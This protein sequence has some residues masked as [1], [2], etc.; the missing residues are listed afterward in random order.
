[1]DNDFLWTLLVTSPW[2]NF[3]G[4]FLVNSSGHFLMVITNSDNTATTASQPT[5]GV[6]GRLCRFGS[7]VNLT[8]S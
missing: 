7:R 4:H 1:M 3:R 6:W 2:V 5:L 8:K